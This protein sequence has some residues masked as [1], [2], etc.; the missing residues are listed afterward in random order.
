MYGKNKP[1]PLTYSNQGYELDHLEKNPKVQTGLKI[2]SA[3]TETKS[4]ERSSNSKMKFSEVVH[5]PW[6]TV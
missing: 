3:C 4:L 2:A 6:K 1:D 5:P